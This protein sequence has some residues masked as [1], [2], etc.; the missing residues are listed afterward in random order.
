MIGKQPAGWE[1]VVVNQLPRS[2]K[3]RVVAGLCGGLLALVGCGGHPDEAASPSPAYNYF[4]RL[5]Y[6]HTVPTTTPAALAQALREPAPP[7]LL[8]ART[9][10]E[11][12]VS[13]LRGA[14]LVPFDSVAALRLPG[15][16]RTQPVVVYCSVGVRSERLGERLHA[17]GFRT[18]HNL[19]GGLFEWVNQG[20]PV[21]DSRGLTQAVHPYSAL[22]GAWLRRGRKAYE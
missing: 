3:R 18:V 14:R 13:H 15:V 2:I 19:H 11:F 9:P 4:L 12:R 20:Y 5:V 10:A 1:M 17:L 6:R 7:L 21:Y 22:W 16:A 8:D